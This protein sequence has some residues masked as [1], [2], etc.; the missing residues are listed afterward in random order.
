MPVFESL[1]SRLTN[2]TV[3]MCVVNVGKTIRHSLQNYI[4]H[5]AFDFEISEKG[6]SLK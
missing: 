1:F 6:L 4:Y 3:Q 5:I 2:F